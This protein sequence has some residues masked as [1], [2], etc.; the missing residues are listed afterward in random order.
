MGLL[1]LILALTFSV[2]PVLAKEGF[3]YSPKGYFFGK[4][5]TPFDVSG[6]NNQEI[7]IG[8]LLMLSE[9][10]KEKITTL[11]NLKRGESKRIN[12]FK[13][14]EWGDAG[15]RA[16]CMDGDIRKIHYIEVKKDKISIP[17]LPFLP[18]YLNT[19]VTVIYGE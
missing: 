13:M 12:L 1:C 18:F 10:E 15:I 17:F 3:S 16:A 4:T 2:N 5:T 14:V 8:R 9:G 6:F 7:P 19:F 11:E